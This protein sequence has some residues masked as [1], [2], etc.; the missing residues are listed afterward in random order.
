MPGELRTLR[1]WAVLFLTDMISFEKIHVKIGRRRIVEDVSFTADE[2]EC[3]GLIGA[4]GSGKST[5]LKAIAGILSVEAGDIIMEGESILSRRGDAR[6][7]GYVPQENPLFGDASGLDHLKLYY[8]GSG[9]DLKKD[10]ESGFPGKLGIAGF[11]AKKVSAMSGG[12]KKRLSLACALAGEP[13]LILMDEPAAALDLPGKAQIRGYVREL[14]A[15]G[16]TIIL[17]THEE[18]DFALCDSFLLMKNGHALIVPG[19]RRGEL[20]SILTEGGENNV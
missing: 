9:R 7:I 13:K 3:I 4:N 2:G 18:E 1:E 17:A 16:K 20:V 10:M 11:A 14:K 12:M 8:S 5:L 19:D 15:A 6:L